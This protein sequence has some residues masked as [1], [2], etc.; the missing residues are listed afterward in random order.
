MEFGVALIRLEKWNNNIGRTVA[1]DRRPMV[2]VDAFA[3]PF[4]RGPGSNDK[5]GGS[6]FRINTLQILYSPL[7]ANEAR[8][9]VA[10]MLLAIE[11]S[12]LSRAISEADQSDTSFL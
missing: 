2:P 8:Q 12:C 7:K 4:Q 9:V 3:G 1:R 10:F 6:T 5:M 11:A